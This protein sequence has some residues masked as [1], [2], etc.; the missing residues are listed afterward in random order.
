MAWQASLD[1]PTDQQSTSIADDLMT[2]EQAAKF[3]GLST[4]SFMAYVKNGSL[5]NAVAIGPNKRWSR[6]FLTAFIEQK[7]VEQQMAVFN[8]KK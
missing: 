7:F 5:P 8:T 1:L 2:Q 3:I 6:R 4:P